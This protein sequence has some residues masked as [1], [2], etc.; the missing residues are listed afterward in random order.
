MCLAHF[1]TFHNLSSSSSRHAS[2]HPEMERVHLVPSDDDDLYT[3]YN[4]FDPSLDTDVSS[5]HQKKLQGVLMLSFH[6][7]PHTRRRNPEC[8]ENELR[9][10]ATVPWPDVDRAPFSAENGCH[11]LRLAANDCSPWG[12][13]H[14]GDNARLS[15]CGR[16]LCPH[17]QTAPLRSWTTNWTSCPASFWRFLAHTRKRLHYLCSL[18]SISSSPDNPGTAICAGSSSCLHKQPPVTDQMGPATAS[19]SAMNLPFPMQ[20]FLLWAATSPEC[21][22]STATL[23]VYEIDKLPCQ[24]LALFGTHQK[25]A[26]LPQFPV[27][28]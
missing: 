11:K 27:L 12:R 14:F 24:F 18:S 25:E 22:D 20:D 8:G 13:L 21:A 9:W 3:G 4:E 17:A 28:N 5:M 1:L 15:S 19:N 6:L 10:K 26:V 23:P 16:R 2:T 7:G